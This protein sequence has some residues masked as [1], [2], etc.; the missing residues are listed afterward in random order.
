MRRPNG[1]RQ[2]APRPERGIRGSFVG[3][4]RCHID[5]TSDVTEAV[6]HVRARAHPVLTERRI[7]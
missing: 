5:D 7:R 2:E 6:V 4:H 3:R 1:R